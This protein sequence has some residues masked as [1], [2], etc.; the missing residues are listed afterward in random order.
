[1]SER[2]NSWSLLAFRFSAT[3]ERLQL[4]RVNEHALYVELEAQIRL[5]TFQ[6]DCTQFCN[7]H[8]TMDFGPGAELGA[9]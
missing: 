5:T 3:H 9:L 4:A 1:M 2:S 6:A 8:S 7:R